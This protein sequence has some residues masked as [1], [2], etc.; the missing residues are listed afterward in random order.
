[1]GIKKA[2]LSTTNNFFLAVKRAA[3]KK[4]LVLKT[5]ENFHQ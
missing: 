5:I 3:K 1:L 4:S 2:E